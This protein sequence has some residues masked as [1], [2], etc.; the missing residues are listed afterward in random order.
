[1]EVFLT[2]FFHASAKQEM[3][4]KFLKLLQGDRTVDADTAKFVRFSH[5]SPSLVAE[6]ERAYMF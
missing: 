4:K 2:R 6:E 5:F 1:M 3:K